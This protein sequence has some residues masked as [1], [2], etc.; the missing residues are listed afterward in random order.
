MQGLDEPNDYNLA[1]EINLNHTYTGFITEQ[2]LDGYP[3]DFDDYKINIPSDGNY[4]ITVSNSYSKNIYY[5]ILDSNLTELLT[6]E[7]LPNSPQSSFQHNLTSG[8]YYIEFFSNADAT[9]YQFPYTFK[10]ENNTLAVDEFAFTEEIKA[11]PNPFLNQLTID[12]KEEI[13]KVEIYNLLGQRVKKIV[14]DNFSNR[15]IIIDLS[16]LIK[17][18]YLAKVYSLNNNYN[19]KLIKN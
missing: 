16:E 17:G 13:F 14:L 8:S 1:Y 18:N 10:I 3:R 4:T 9:S 6:N 2:P 12:A 15:K 11:Y 7:I 5:R 19:I